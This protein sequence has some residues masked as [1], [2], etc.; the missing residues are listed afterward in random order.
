MRQKLNIA[1]VPFDL[2]IEKLSNFRLFFSKTKVLDSIVWF[3]KIILHYKRTPKYENSEG[4][5]LSFLVG[6]A[7]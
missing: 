7:E 4:L 1:S 2:F 6:L 3:E 5:Q